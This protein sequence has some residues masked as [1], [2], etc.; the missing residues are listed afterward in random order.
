MGFFRKKNNPNEDVLAALDAAFLGG[1]PLSG[2]QQKKFDDSFIQKA[3][4]QLMALRNEYAKENDPE[5]FTMKK[6][7]FD[8]LGDLILA[9]VCSEIGIGITNALEVH[10][11]G[12][13]HDVYHLTAKRLG[14]TGNMLDWSG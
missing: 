3:D 5:T 14:V 11:G 7:E 9:E 2:R 1:A 4:L 6:T 13:L 12:L 8:S 10:S